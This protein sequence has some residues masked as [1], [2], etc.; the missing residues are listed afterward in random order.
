MVRSGGNS[1]K[2]NSA[3]YDRAA[4]CGTPYNEAAVKWY[5]KAAEQECPEAQYELGD[6]YSYGIGVAKDLEQ[7]FEWYQKSAEQGDCTAQ[8]N[9]G[10]CYENGIG[11]EKDVIKATEWYQ[12]SAEQGN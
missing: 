1:G 5:T 9:L 2:C 11:V 7:A 4:V 10:Y 12:K 6:C 3:V 8:C